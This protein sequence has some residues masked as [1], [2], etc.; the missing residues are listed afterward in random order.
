MSQTPPCPLLPDDPQPARQGDD[1]G[2]SA[3]VAA[4]TSAFGDRTRREVFLYLRS[5]PDATASEVAAEFGLHP[6]VA[7]HH[8]DKLVSSG[9]V[10]TR[11]ARPAKAGAG[12]PSKR[13]RALPL[14]GAELLPAVRNDLVVRLLARTLDELGAQR[15]EQI[16]NDV[17]QDYG[18]ELAQAFSPSRSGR[19]LTWAMSAVVDMLTAQGFAARVDCEDGLL[20]V[21]A[22][23]CPFGA[24][25]AGNPLLC[26][27]ERGMVQGMLTSLAGHANN[28]VTV[29]SKARGDA[30]CLT[31]I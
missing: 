30:V 15:A 29:S 21:V 10:E 13:Y 24:A 4:V 11:L 22:E 1:E 8:L 18:A 5:H 6:N 20:G 2:F 7:R 26:A 9:H 17:G 28:A 3:A 25:A 31:R 14:A 12:R 23:H 16:A 27:V 19:S